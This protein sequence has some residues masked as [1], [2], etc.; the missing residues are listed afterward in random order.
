VVNTL[1]LGANAALSALL[2]P[3]GVT[4]WGG[5][6]ETGVALSALG[7]GFL[8]GAPVFRALAHRVAP[9]HL[10]GATLI[11]LG[12]CFAGLFAVTSLIAALGPIVLLGVA[13]ATA[14]GA[15]QLTL[16]RATPNGVLGRASAAMFT[17]E[18]AATLAGALV[19]P[20][21]AEATSIP[22][23]AVAAGGLTVTSGIVAWLLLPRAVG[24]R[25]PG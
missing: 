2:V 16:Q 7:A 12:L 21:V 9:A 5:S 11:L 24:H 1:F 23:T 10:L 3:H 19:G 8:I 4:V 14:L 6:G 25:F 22:W 15:V 20:A 18:A 13:G 17:L